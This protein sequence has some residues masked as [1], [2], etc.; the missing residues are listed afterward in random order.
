MAVIFVAVDADV[1]EAG[2]GGGDDG[3][4]ADYGVKAHRCS[5][6]MVFE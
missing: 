1:G 3:A 5:S 2:V 6:G 4:V